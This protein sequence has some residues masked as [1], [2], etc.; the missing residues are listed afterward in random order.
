MCF[1]IS[2]AF[3]PEPFPV[4]TCSCRSALTCRAAPV[5]AGLL[6]EDFA[7]GSLNPSLFPS[8][9]SLRPLLPFAPLVEVVMAEAHQAVGFQFSVTQEGVDVRLS[10]QALTE[11]YLSGV[12]S[13]RKRLVRLKVP[14]PFT[15]ACIWCFLFIVQ[16]FQKYCARMKKKLTC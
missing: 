10:H 4:D 3:S 15:L 13:W 12:R 6:A 7:N 11:I 2:F 14:P 9:P 8:C 16:F 1:C 5:G